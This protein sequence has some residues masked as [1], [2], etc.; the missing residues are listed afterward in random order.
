MD[1]GPE[2]SEASREFSPSSVFLPP[3]KGLELGRQDLVAALARCA[4]AKA[5]WQSVLWGLQYSQ[6]AP[7]PAFLCP[8]QC[9]ISAVLPQSFLL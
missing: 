4:E 1:S 8:A 5:G 7:S 9:S 2:G 3:W 6:E